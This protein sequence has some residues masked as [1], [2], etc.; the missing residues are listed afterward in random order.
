[1]IVVGL[2]GNGPGTHL[3]KCGI[4]VKNAYSSPSLKEKKKKKLFPRTSQVLLPDFIEHHSFSWNLIV[5]YFSR[6][7]V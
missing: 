4:V 1:M 3:A 5:L 6:T 7:K 2:L